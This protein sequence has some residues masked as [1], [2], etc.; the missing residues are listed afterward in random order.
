M[1]IARISAAAILAAC[2]L[3]PVPASAQV[4]DAV[5]RGTLVCG[6][7]PFLK[8]HLRAAMEVT[9]KGGSA[10]YKQPV[11]D[12]VK[13]TQIG[14]ET[15]SGSVDGQAIKLSGGWKG[16]QPSFEATY[17]GTFVR[18]SARLSGKQV[19]THE[20]KSYTRTCSGAVKRPFAAFI[21]NDGKS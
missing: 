19:W 3:S 17:T 11:I 12:A 21:K 20:G 14:M 7:L 13:G 15:G 9:I 6:A 10:E 1:T 4:R 16:S 18:R 8:G 5:Y 2:I